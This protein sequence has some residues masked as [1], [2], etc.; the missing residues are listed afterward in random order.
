FSPEV[1]I[2]DADIAAGAE[3]GSQHW[4]ETMGSTS[5]LV[6]GGEQPGMLPEAIRLAKPL[7]LPS[8]L[9]A[10]RQVAK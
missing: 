3:P 8:L 9:S 10:M 1:I 4:L 6:L 2:L 7:R 5:V